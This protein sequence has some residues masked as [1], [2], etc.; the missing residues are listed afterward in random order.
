MGMPISMV[1]RGRHAHDSVGRDAW[2]QV[3][4]SLRRV[5]RDFSTYRATSFVSRLAR[6]EIELDDCPPEVSEV[7]ALGKLAEQRSHGAFQIMRQSPDGTPTLDPNGVVKGWA[8]E[9]AGSALSLLDDTSFCLSAG[10]DMIC[11][12]AAS[13]DQPWRIGVEDPHD[14]TRLVAVVPIHHGAVATSGTTHRGAHVV[15]GRTGLPPT[16]I[17]SVTVVAD[18]LTWADIDA[19]A[20]FARG[21]DAAR[22]LSDDAE[23]IALVVWSDGS[24]TGTSPRRPTGPRRDPRPRTGD[25]A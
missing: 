13:D 15:D 19:T 23:R 7:L 12:A 17:A 3:L 21:R 22:W 5:D 6:G 16:G 9:R 4:R 2:E 24:I 8:V 18:T 1:L 25:P 10:G 14:P 11:H 20:A